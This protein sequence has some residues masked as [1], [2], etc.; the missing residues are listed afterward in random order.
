MDN[1]NKINGDKDLYDRL[2]VWMADYEDPTLVME[3]KEM[4]LSEAERFLYHQAFDVMYD[5]YQTCTEE[6]QNDVEGV[7]V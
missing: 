3:D 7:P 5:I 1:L 4:T 2:S 6:T